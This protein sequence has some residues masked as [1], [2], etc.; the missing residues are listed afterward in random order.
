MLNRL[1]LLAS[2]SLSLSGPLLAPLQARAQTAVATRANPAQTTGRD[3]LT[4]YLTEIA[5][6]HIQSRRGA[7]SALQTPEDAR[8]RQVRVRAL[9]SEMIGFERQT[10]PVATVSAG[11]SH[12][13]GFDIERLRYESLPGYW[14]TANVYAPREPGP[15]PAIIVQ[16]GHGTDGKLSN[17]GMA[18]NLVRAGFVVLAIDIVGEGERIQHLDPEIGASKVGRPTGEHSMGFAQNLP[19]GG[20][21]SRYFIQD[22]VRGVDYLMARPNV[23]D[24]RIGAFGCSGGGTMTAY[25]AALDPRI[26]AAAS[27]CYINDFDHL[28]A[29][30]GPGPQ[31]AEQ[32]IPFFLERG[33]DLPDWIEAAAP[34][35]YAV[36]AT[37]EDMFPIE[38]ARAAY[39]EA[40]RFYGLLGAEDQIT[41]I[42][43][44]GGHG[45]LGPISPQI[46]NF[47]VRHLATPCDAGRCDRE[48]PQPFLN[49]QLGD[50]SRLLA[51][52]TGQL[53]SSIMGQSLQT[54][55]LARAN[56]N[57]P[58]PPAKETRADRLARLRAAIKDVAR[59]TVQP[60]DPAP[61][62][63]QTIPS[64]RSGAIARLS[65]I[66][67]QVAPNLEIHAV[68]ST[69][70]QGPSVARPTL[71]LMT[72]Q[73]PAQFAA[74]GGLFDMWAQAGWNVLALEPR[75]AGGAEEIKS[76][77]TGDW[78][79]LSLRA[80]LIG[81]TPVGMRVD[82]A[83]AALNWLAIQPEVDEH[84][85]SVTGVGALG[86]VA[87]HAAVLDERVAQAISE[88]AIISYR[89]FV[90]R[91]ISIN[92]AEVNMP[93]VLTRY[94]LPDLMSVLGDRLTLVNP[95]SSVG[96]ALSAA[97]VHERA[98][99]VRNIIIRGPRDAAPSPA[100]AR[101]VASP[102]L[103]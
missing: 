87:L 12:E 1:L 15:H 53:S 59:T 91:P 62:V 25:L 46:M 86:P 52:P 76:P 43:G 3:R 32:S 95:V 38:G 8:L 94:D 72:A 73:D 66:A 80:L 16:P 93:G 83:L 69:P 92:M 28:L 101:P 35:P 102:S 61:A 99:D 33:L 30:G 24:Q 14:V 41:L 103:S 90:E 98:P 45:A 54:L 74:Q 26:K 63:V 100:T 23:D 71:L 89:E 5:Q 58:A 10:G 77:L 81:K 79:L 85:L 56:A 96:Q 44:P 42:E 34:R 47:F 78:T 40:R 75:G 21:V 29:S 65:N 31:D 55:A 48:A 11:L 60:R 88:N 20:H 70:A 22:A 50:S 67:F 97:K 39:A 17:Y 4:A 84:Q 82:D 36:V 49:P 51:T 37:T 9:L 64:K 19:V 13:D 7:I 6:Q 18:V 27:A 57:R 68:F 2:L